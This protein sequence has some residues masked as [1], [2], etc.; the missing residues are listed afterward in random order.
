MKVE[1]LSI[2]LTDQAGSLVRITSLL[3]GSGINIKALSL[4]DSGKFGHLRVIVNDTV[5]ARQV[6]VENSFQVEASEILVLEVPDR[7]GGVARVLTIIND[8]G[9]TVLY[10]YAFA[11]KAGKSGLIIFCIDDIDK[12]VE[13]LGAAGIRALS[14]EEIFAL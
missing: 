1:Q 3:A 7:P 12:A 2:T 5:R 11:Q 13:A 14:A 10:L 9:L 8:A 6:L 4:A